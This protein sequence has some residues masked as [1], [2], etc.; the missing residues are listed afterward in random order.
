MH[1]L[2]HDAIGIPL[3]REDA[4]RS[5]NILT[6]GLEQIAQ[7]IVQSFAIAEALVHHSDTGDALIVMVGMVMFVIVVT[8]FATLVVMLMRIMVMVF[9]SGFFFE[10]L[11]ID[12]HGP[13]EI[14]ATDIE[15]LFDFDL[16]VGRAVDF[17]QRIHVADA[18]LQSIEFFRRCEI[19]FVQQN[20]VG[21][22]DLLLG[23]AALVVDVQEDVLRINEGDHGVDE[24]FF[25]HLRIGE[26]GL[27]DGAGIGET[28]RLD[29]DV[30]ELIPALHQIAQD[31][32]Q[33]AADGA[34][35]AAVVHF[36][37]LFF[38]VDHE[39]MIDADLA[40]LVLDHGDAQAMI[41]GENAVEESG[42]ASAEVSGENGHGYARFFSRH[43]HK[44][45][46]G[47]ASCKKLGIKREEC[48]FLLQI[49]CGLETF[50]EF[51]RSMTPLVAIVGF[52][53]SGKTTFLK[54]LLPVLRAR[55]VSPYVVINDYQ[56]AKIDAQQL[57][58]LTDEVRAISGDCV[59][60]GSRDELMETLEKFE[61]KSG[62]VVLLETNGTTDSDQL[63]EL[64]SLGES[65]KGFSLPLQVSL[66]D[67]KR[68]QKRF[69]HNALER[70]QARTA[71]HIIISRLDSE[72]AKRVA[73]VEASFASHHIRGLRVT[74]EAFAEELASLSKE[75]EGQSRVAKAPCGCGHDHHH[76][77]H[78]HGHHHHDHEEEHEHQ[79]GHSHDHHGKHHFASLEV[80][81]P[82]IV[83]RSAFQKFLKDLPETV[84]RAKGMVRFVEE[85]HEVY[86]F[87]KVDRSDA[88]QFFPVGA[89]AA[90]KSPLALFIGPEL[91][92]DELRE[93]ALA[94][95]QG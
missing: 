27:D 8:M 92:E 14:K 3:N 73:E 74:V 18:L 17:G 24:E 57:Q 80:G 11:R 48:F 61:H 40:E 59:C 37:E 67:A 6:L 95:K 68:W 47:R 78:D 65:L 54:N 42:F 79:H 60:C 51:T 30:I 70:E 86:I 10:K 39:F 43:P 9:V 84:I 82:E 93:A 44:R 2:K 28:G 21:K 25:L 87:Q 15:D 69:W 20:D 94:L 72:S 91:P 29:E 63:I 22:S 55:G 62:R 66:I 46:Q 88:P 50:C 41:F 19:A 75:L 7:P 4:F 49:I 45:T 26:E 52:L 23:F 90:Q 64:L 5:E 35:D 77:D 16:C 33:I 12:L 34:A 13:V 83:S 85:P 89:T 36:K 81:L 53:G 71:S 1:A 56:N 31:A 38:G 32:D 58:A 76:H